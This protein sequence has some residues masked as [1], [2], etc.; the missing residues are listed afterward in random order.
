MTKRVELKLVASTTEPGSLGMRTPDGGL[1][2]H[3]RT[4]LVQAGFRPGDRVMIVPLEASRGPWAAPKAIELTRTPQGLQWQLGVCG[5]VLPLGPY[6]EA[7]LRDR[8]GAA[9]RR[10]NQDDLA[11]A[12]Q[13]LPLVVLVPLGDLLKAAD[14]AQPTA[15]ERMES[16]YEGRRDLAGRLMGR[17]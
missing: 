16:Y 2:G 17:R 13:T 10:S 8:I 11:D 12:S 9:L 6:S 7:V 3:I 15:D 1:F 14:E 5:S 4:A